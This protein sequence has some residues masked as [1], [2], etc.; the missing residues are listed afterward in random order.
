MPQN[1]G[2]YNLQKWRLIV[3]FLVASLL[4]SCSSIQFAYNNIDYWIRWKLR[5]YVD[6][7]SQQEMEF[8][9]ALNSFFHWH[10][11]TQ[12][13]KYADFLNQLADKVD[14]GQLE[15]PQLAPVEQEVRHFISN[16]S[17]NAFNLILPIVAQLTPQQIDRLQHNLTKKQQKTLEKW[18]RSPWKIQRRRDRQ[19]RRESRRWLGTLTEQQKQLIAAWVKQV[20]YNPVLRNE[21]Q[22]IWQNHAIKLLRQKPDGYLQQL[23]DLLENPEQL[24]SDEYRKTQEQRKNQA[25]EL[26]EQ[27]LS[28]T[29]PTQR[30]HLS[31]TLREY[32]QDF[33]TLANQ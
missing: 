1:Q 19:I 17:N 5:D 23:R 14:K 33:R 32:A 12:L 26:G 9:G 8:Q 20:E 29:S 28:S 11:Q 13:P 31:R 4:S 25:R 2:S 7:N 18:Q 21:Q 30:R 15:N 16:A 6:L 27:I 22:L 24:W 3:L 10:R